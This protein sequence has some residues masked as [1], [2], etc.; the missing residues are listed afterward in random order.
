MKRKYWIT[1]ALSCSMLASIA[2]TTPQQ[3]IDFHSRISSCPTQP[4]ILA[5]K[6]SN[7][8][9]PLDTPL[10]TGVM[11]PWSIITEDRPET[12][13]WLCR[14]FMSNG[15]TSRIKPISLTSLSTIDMEHDELSPFR[16]GKPKRMTIL[17]AIGFILVGIIDTRI[18]AGHPYFPDL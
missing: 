9:H 14:S 7:R 1:A 8:K 15:A 12:D 17:Q 16:I 18:N 6:S 4:A 5:K 10:F 3:V 2:Q 11:P 13:Y